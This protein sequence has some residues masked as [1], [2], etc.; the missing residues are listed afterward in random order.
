[1]LPLHHSRTK[2]SNLAEIVRF[3]DGC[4][5]RQQPVKLFHSVGSPQSLTAVV[6]AVAVLG[7][8][9]PGQD[10]AAGSLRQLQRAGSEHQRV[11]PRGSS[12][13]GAGL[14]HVPVPVPLQ[15]VQTFP[16]LTKHQEQ[17]SPEPVAPVENRTVGRGEAMRLR[18]RLS[19]H[20]S[21]PKMIP[22]LSCFTL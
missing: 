1:M 16:V 5:R 18:L 8:V 22:S 19:A 2:H 17:P 15:R 10:D 20:F 3:D 21:N 13:H 11:R 7:N 12:R 4:R 14:R 6:C 9:R